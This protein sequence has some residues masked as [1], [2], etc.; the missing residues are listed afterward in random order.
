MSSR[1]SRNG[2]TWISTVFKRNRRSS[3]NCPDA[4][5]AGRSVFVAE[6]TRTFTL[7]GRDE[8]TRSISPDSNTRSSLACWRRGTLPISSRKIVPPSASSKR[9]I[10]SVRASVNAP[11]TWPNSSLSKTPSGIAPVFTATKAREARGESACKV[12]ATTSLP[13]PWSPVMRTFASDGP[14]REI[15]SMTACMEGALA[16]KSGLPSA[17]SRRFSASSRAA[18]CRARCSSTCVRM[19]EMRRSFSQ[20]FWIKSRAPR[21]IAST[22]SST[23]AQAVITITGTVASSETICDR[24]SS[25]SWPEVVSRV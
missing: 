19:I 20:G 1:R 15:V 8:P 7:R 9:P 10:L 21:R 5:A 14:T 2:G 6:R 11:F 23:L 25:P 18:R 4:Q 3:R 12:C 13:V 17:R 16:M 24:R 22:A